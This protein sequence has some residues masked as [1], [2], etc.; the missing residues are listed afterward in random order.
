MRIPRSRVSPSASY[1]TI[2]ETRWTRSEGADP[3]VPFPARS[4]HAPA[5]RQDCTAIPHSL[6]T[7]CDAGQCLVV[8]CRDGF[9]VGRDGKTCVKKSSKTGPPPQAAHD[10]H[11]RP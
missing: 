3:T 6:S 1:E 11:H 4:S 9:A 5:H 2:S 10:P 8:R 7:S